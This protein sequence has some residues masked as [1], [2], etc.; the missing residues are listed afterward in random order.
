ME[1]LPSIRI[2][3]TPTHPEHDHN[4]SGHPGPNCPRNPGA[5]KPRVSDGLR[6]MDMDMLQLSAFL[7]QLFLTHATAAFALTAAVPA[8][9]L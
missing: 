4:L 2:S 7:S 5:P 9:R 6:Q 8:F 1:T 3:S